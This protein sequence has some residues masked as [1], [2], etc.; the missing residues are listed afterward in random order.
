M[1]A[2][3]K[4]VLVLPEG[5][6][7]PEL[8]H[9]NSVQSQIRAWYEGKQGCEMFVLPHGYQ[10]TMIENGKVQHIAGPPLEIAADWLEEKGR[11]DEADN[12]RRLAV[13]VG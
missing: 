8:S 11:G 2:P 9:I 1:A 4:F 7:P 13:E 3:V 6:P 12:L 5:H 10:L